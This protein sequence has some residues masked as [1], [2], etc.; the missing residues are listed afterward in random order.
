MRLFDGIDLQATV[1]KIQPIIEKQVAK[2][3]R[4]RTESM[5]NF[6][7]HA[8]SLVLEG[9]YLKAKTLQKLGK[10]NGISSN[11]IANH[12]PFFSEF[13]MSV[14]ALQRQLKSVKRYLRE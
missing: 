9:A 11:A 6:P 10:L 12:H 14:L 7:N 2:K 8:A 4:T 5:V 3:G 1:E 13:S